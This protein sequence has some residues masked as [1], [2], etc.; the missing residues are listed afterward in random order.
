MMPGF[1][2]IASFGKKEIPEAFDVTFPTITP[3]MEKTIQWP[4]VWVKQSITGK[5]GK[6]KIFSNDQD[7]FITTDG[8]FLNSQELKRRYGS[9]DLFGLLKKMFISHPTS[10]PSEL[11]GDFD[12]LIVEKKKNTLTLFTNHVG[13][14][15][16]FYFLEP[17]SQILVFGTELLMVSQ[18]MKKLGLVPKLDED[19]ANCLLAFGYMLGDRTLVKNVRKVP[20]GSILHFQEGKISF[21]RYFPFTCEP[22]LDLSKEKIIQELDERFRTAVQAEYE[23]DLEYGYQHIATLSGGLDSRMNVCYARKLGYEKILTYTFSQSNYLDEKIAKKIAADWGFDFLFFSLDNGNYLKEIENPILAGGG[24]TTSLGIS[25]GLFA[26]SRINSTPFGMIHTGQL[27]DAIL[28]TYL[29]RHNKRKKGKT[30]TAI[31]PILLS[32][33]EEIYVKEQKKFN[34]PELFK[35]SNRGVNGI[36]GGYR[37]GEQFSEFS[38]PFLY[39][40]FL[41]FCLRIPPL[42]RSQEKIY[43]E[44]VLKR[45]PE[46]AKYTWE[47]TGTKIGATRLTKYAIKVFRYGKRKTLGVKSQYSMNPLDRWY[48]EN[49]SLSQ[50]LQKFF[51][52]NHFLLNSFPKL[53]KNSRELF[54][55]G[56]L[57]EKFKVIS[58]LGAIFILGLK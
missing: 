2:G 54:L 32:E 52:N 58:L 51:S 19:G 49:P 6:E 29:P 14:K 53:S 42:Y 47:K 11:R 18:T 12:G 35:L 25:H 45:A 30:N 38:S 46:A 37:G 56:D 34:M 21:Q 4:G 13:S 1:L 40:E 27:G 3:R 7:F 33:L 20:P 22:T 43:L 48:L 15:W 26:L 23:K 10:F 41:E 50:T 17:D 16:V 5:F 24:M 36:F 55:S 31:S 44:W 28:G 8:V 57:S 39:P 9:N